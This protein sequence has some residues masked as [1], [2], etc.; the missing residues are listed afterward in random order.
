MISNTR[1]FPCVTISLYSYLYYHRCVQQCL[2]HLLINKSTHYSIKSDERFSFNQWWSKRTMM[3]FI[4]IDLC[5]LI[6][7]FD[8]SVQLMITNEI[9]TSLVLVEYIH[10]KHWNTY[11]L[12][13]SGI[14]FPS[15]ETNE[16]NMNY[17]L[18]HLDYTKCCDGRTEL[19][20]ELQ[21]TECC[22]TKQ[23]RNSLNHT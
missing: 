2:S 10:V 1:R 8:W 6:S 4:D 18:L 7:S 17:H 14:R 19:D 16:P 11:G 22:F 15:D 13:W 20:T 3:W 5:L 12:G 9:Y 23:W 21:S